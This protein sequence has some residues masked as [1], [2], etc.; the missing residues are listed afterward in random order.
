MEDSC[1]DNGLRTWRERGSCL[2]LECCCVYI[3]PMYIFEGVRILESHKQILP[4]ASTVQMTQS[5]YIYETVCLELLHHLKETAFRVSAYVHWP[6]ISLL[7]GS[8]E[9]VSILWYLNTLLITTHHKHFTISWLDYTQAT[10]LW[11]L[12]GNHGRH[13]ST[14]VHQKIRNRK[15]VSAWF[16]TSGISDNSI[17]GFRSPAFYPYNPKAISDNKFLPSTMYKKGDSQPGNCTST[18]AD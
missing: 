18:S 2:L 5:D 9:L 7:S 4:A 6:D 1:K 8:F 12:S 3:P 15:V 16:V 10:E 17:K 11:L 14:S 13:A